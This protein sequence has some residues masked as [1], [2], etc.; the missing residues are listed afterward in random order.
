MFQ[1]PKMPGIFQERVIES[2]VRFF[3]PHQHLQYLP[4]LMT[5][6]ML[7]YVLPQIFEEIGASK[8]L[9]SQLGKSG[10]PQDDMWQLQR[11]LDPAIV[12]RRRGREGV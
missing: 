1:V 8:Q 10:A 6:P 2:E 3:R 9:P 5:M 12:V 7:V 4:L 11:S